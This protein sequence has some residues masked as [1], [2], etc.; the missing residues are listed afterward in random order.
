MRFLTILLSNKPQLASWGIDNTFRVEFQLQMQRDSPNG[1]NLPFRDGWYN[2]KKNISGIYHITEWWFND[3]LPHYCKDILEMIYKLG[4]P[5]DWISYSPTWPLD[6]A[7]IGVRQRRKTFHGWRS[8]KIIGGFACRQKALNQ[9]IDI[10][11][12]EGK[13]PF[14]MGKSTINGW[15]I[16]I[17]NG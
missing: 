7:P 5:H 12:N 3:D 2:P 17:F 8:W 6:C 4:L 13:A 11:K 14:L 1:V 15:K 16:A 10:G 9:W